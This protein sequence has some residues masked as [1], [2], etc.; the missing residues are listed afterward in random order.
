MRASVTDPFVRR[1]PRPPRQTGKNPAIA[2]ESFARPAR[3]SAPK[4]DRLRVRRA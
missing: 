4:G 1:V 3:D 2:A